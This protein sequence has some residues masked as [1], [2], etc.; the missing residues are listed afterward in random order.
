MK[1]S[2]VGLLGVGV[3]MG[4]FA[5]FDS[6]L[7][8]HYLAA[9]VL[10]VEAAVLHNFVWH[11]RYTWRDR[12]HTGARDLANRLARFHAGN[13]L[14]SI[15]GNLALMRLLVGALGVNHY[16]ASGASIAICSL[17]NFAIS[18]WFV[19]RGEGIPPRDSR[20]AQLE[21]AAAASSSEKRAA[22]DSGLE[23]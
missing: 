19:F 3:Q 15:L 17:L 22:L 14:V 16:V 7:G 6:G 9:T 21:I 4:C 11:E 12:P 23:T 10:A 1:F 8:L 13:G 5:L 18:E 2:A 20:P